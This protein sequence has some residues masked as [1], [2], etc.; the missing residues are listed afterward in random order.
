MSGSY[1]ACPLQSRWGLL[2]W[3]LV[4]GGRLHAVADAQGDVL[5]SDRYE[6]PASAVAWRTGGFDAALAEA[7]KTGKPV[8]VDFTAS[9][10]PPC[11]VIKHAVWPDAQ[12]ARAVNEQY[13][14]LMVDVDDPQNAE[15]AQTSI[16]P[17]S[18]VCDIDT[19]ASTTSTAGC[20][21]KRRRWP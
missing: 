15:V 4:L 21:T 5:Q 9:W 3:A 20:S 19:T 12:V 7:A 1:G 17:L 6:G 10:C 8:L 13:V 14:P 16:T 18:V 2:P 11:K